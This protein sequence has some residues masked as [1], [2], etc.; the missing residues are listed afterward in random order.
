MLRMLAL[1]K[2]VRILPAWHQR[3]PKRQVKAP[4]IWVRDVSWKEKRITRIESALHARQNELFFW[5]TYQGTQLDLLVVMGKKRRGY[6]LTRSKS[7]T[8][9][10]AA[11]IALEDLRL[12]S[13]DIVHDG[14]KTRRI[15]PKVRAVAT[16]RIP[17][18]IRR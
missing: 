5:S 7:P 4:M 1:A 10:K 18:D 8:L 2:L 15:A 11:A 14:P 3:L 16:R 9:G 13:L 6:V 17:K 12:T